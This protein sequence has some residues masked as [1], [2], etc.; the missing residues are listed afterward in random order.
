MWVDKK[1]S[2]LET[3]IVG[4]FALPHIWLRT[5]IVTGISIV[6]TILYEEVPQ[7]HYSLTPAPFTIIGLPLGIFL[8]FRNNTAY[9]R[10]WEG[11]KLWGSLVNTTRSLTRQV[12]TLIEPQA[13]A[14]PVESTPE[15]IKKFENEVVHMVI[16]YVH[17]LRHHL[18]DTKPFEPL[19]H[20]LPKEEVEK[21]EDEENVPLA[22]LQR[23]GEKFVEA[24][25][26]K[27]VHAF[28]IPVLEGSLTGLTDI[29]GAC[30]RIKGTPIPFSY[31]VLMHR[32]VAGYCTLLPFGLMESIKWATPAVVLA[33]SYCFFGLDAIGDEIEQPFGMDIND[34][35]LKSISRNIERNLRKRIGETVPPPVEPKRGVLT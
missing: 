2:W 31:T 3:V 23:M 20:I 28:H 24:R 27:W 19:S 30:E 25:R 18:R 32:I 26:K 10:F 7:L 6:V 9:D 33:I 8:G 11:R 35:P 13:D 22:L 29:Q 4:G 34:L 14:D 5:C 17:A 12:L 15:A 21:L 16:A 1:R